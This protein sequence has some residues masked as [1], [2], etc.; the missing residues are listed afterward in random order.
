MALKVYPSEEKLGLGDILRATSSLFLTAKAKPGESAQKIDITP[1]DSLTASIEDYDVFPFDDILVTSCN[2][3]NN[4]Y[5]SVPEV[6]AAR[7]TRS[8][9]QSIGTT[10]SWT[11]WATPFRPSWS[12]IR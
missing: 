1:P 9:S 10:K 6:W 5:F 4:S 11:S 12:M 8:T 7:K 3:L 2:N